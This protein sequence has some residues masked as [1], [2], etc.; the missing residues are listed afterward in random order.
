MRKLKAVLS[1]VNPHNPSRIYDRLGKVNQRRQHNE[2]AGERGA[3]EG[4]GSQNEEQVSV[5]YF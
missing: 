3:T 1:L 2:K 5:I 4:S